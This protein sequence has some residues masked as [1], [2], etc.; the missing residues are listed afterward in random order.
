M[1]TT[2]ISFLARNIRNVS[3]LD[4]LQYIVIDQLSTEHAHRVR[5]A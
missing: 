4:Q 5:T 2:A 3:V 1:L